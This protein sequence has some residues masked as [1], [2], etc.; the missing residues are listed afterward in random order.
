VGNGFPP[1]G[2]S[3]FF[4]SQGVLRTGLSRPSERSERACLGLDNPAEGGGEVAFFKSHKRVAVS[5]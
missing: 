2:E 3:S 4:K 5:L 1:E